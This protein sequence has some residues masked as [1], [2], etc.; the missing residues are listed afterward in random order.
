MSELLT[1]AE[2]ARLIGAGTTS[3]KRWADTGLLD[4]IRTAGG[5][6]RFTRDALTRFARLQ[7]LGQPFVEEVQRWVDVLISETSHE[8]ALLRAR[9]RATS[10]Y[11]V[12]DELVPALRELRFRWAQDCGGAF[13]ERRT[14]SERL[15]RALTCVAESLHVPD[16]AP[17]V[18]LA[19]VEAEEDDLPLYLAEVCLRE[20]GWTSVWLGAAAP[21]SAIRQ[22]VLSSD[23]IRLVL[24]YASE[25]C[26][27]SDGLR[28]VYVTLGNLCQR[29]G[30]GIALAGE[31]PW[32]A[33]PRYGLRLQGLR[34][35]ETWNRD[36]R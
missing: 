15:S 16:N 17:R 22:Q 27:D 24:L 5:H 2:A 3:V 8:L 32:P 21:T 9:R 11:R 12:G 1:T 14:A 29:R 7:E 10:W 26:R 4:C 28:E 35:L 19:C 34:E 23:R 30:V 31:G 33:A 6:R 25:A 18:L 36:Y 20:S 13:V